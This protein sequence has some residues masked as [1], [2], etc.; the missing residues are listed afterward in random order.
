MSPVKNPKPTKVLLKS[1]D[2]VVEHLGAI[3]Y[4]ISD[5]NFDETSAR[6]A[7]AM[8][9][10]IWPKDKILAE[11]GSLMSRVFPAEYN[12][13]VV[14]PNVHVPCMCPHH[15]LPVIM[16]VTLAYI[17]KPKGPKIGLSKLARIAKVYGKQPIM[18]EEYTSGLLQIMSDG[19][20]SVGAAVYVKGYHTCMALR[21]V[22]AYDSPTIT[23]ALHGAFFTN[24]ATRSEFFSIA[25]SK[26]SL[27]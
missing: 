18:Q 16:R 20:D 7:K 4:D 22:N 5:E 26:T 19:L 3:G 17:P 21:G 2:G 12:S 10:L 14:Q 25:N 27:F 24:P 6:A 23:N 9:E 15:L 1:Y 11:I 8:A 13:I